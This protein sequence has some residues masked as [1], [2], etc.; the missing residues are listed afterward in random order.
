MR[1]TERER[2]RERERARPPKRLDDINDETAAATDFATCK[3][4]KYNHLSGGDF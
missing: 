3:N 4:G 1:E 2:E